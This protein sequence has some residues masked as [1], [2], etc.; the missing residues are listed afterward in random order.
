M[1][2]SDRDFE[3]RVNAVWPVRVAY[4]TPFIEDTIRKCVMFRSL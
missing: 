1:P 4:E 2:F 3:L